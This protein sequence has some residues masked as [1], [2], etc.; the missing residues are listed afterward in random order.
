MFF[1]RPFIAYKNLDLRIAKNFKLPWGTN[2]EFSAAAFNV[3]DSVN[4]SYS[5]WGAGS[6]T[7]PTLEENGTTGLGRSFQVG[8]K[9]RF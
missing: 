4:R 9:F 7:N 8:A 6:G 3:F 1:P 2:I 5:A